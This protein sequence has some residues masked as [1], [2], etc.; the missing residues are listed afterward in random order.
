MPTPYFAIDYAAARKALVGAV[1]LGTGLGNNRIIR[2]QAQGPVQPVPPRP[3][4]SFTFRMAA[5]RTPFR[6]STVFENVAGNEH[7]TI[8]GYR[9]IAVD[10]TFH[11][12]SQDDAYGYAT[13]FQAS[14][15][16]DD[17]LRALRAY[18]F[19]VWA[20]QDV[21]D[22]TAMMATGYEGRAMVEF[23]MWTR[24]VS[25]VAVGDIQSVPLI[26]DVKTHLELTI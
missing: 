7:V 15:Y 18:N 3:Y 23:E 21:T 4:A 9:G 12:E 24:I 10:I 22:L 14:L 19:A 26:G 8:S 13:T 6:D 17:V 20:V 25:T 11:G 1:S 2:E 5:M 16:R